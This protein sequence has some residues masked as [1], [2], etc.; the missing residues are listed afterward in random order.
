MFLIKR[1]NG[2]TLI[3][4]LFVLGLW[5]VLFLLT[6]PMLVQAIEGQQEQQFFKTFESDIL[7]IQSL[8]T[9][10]KS[11]IRINF[12]QDHYTIL[13]GETVKIRR[14]IPKDWHINLRVI[15]NISFDENGRIK[16]PGTMSIKTKR[17]EYVVVFPFGKGRGYVV[18]Q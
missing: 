9:Q 6:V 18:K 2:F 4:M 16:E 15:K 3:E 5:S 13:S 11:H 14:K 8:A 10:S 12:S 7:Y 1:A 17:S